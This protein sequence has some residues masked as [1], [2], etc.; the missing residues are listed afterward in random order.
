MSKKTK[1]IRV[2]RQGR[3]LTGL[4]YRVDGDNREQYRGLATDPENRNRKLRGPWTYTYADAKGWRTQILSKKDLVKRGQADKTL[5]TPKAKM[6]TIED[7]GREFLKGIKDGVI[8]SNKD[9]P[10]A[11]STY[12]GYEQAFRDYIFP[13]L[14][15][16]RVNE[17]RRSETQRFIDAIKAIRAPRTTRNI[18][19]ALCALYTYLLPRHDELEHDPTHG[20]K[21]PK[22]GK[23]RQ[24]FAEWD[25]IAH[26]MGCLDDREG[27]PFALAF[28]EGLRNG[29]IR[30]LP[31]DHIDLDEGWIKVAWSL[32]PKE[33][34]KGPKSYSSVRDI[35]IFDQMYPYLERQMERVRA[36]GPIVPSTDDR[37]GTLLLPS[38]RQTR[39][40]ARTYG[41]SFMNNCMESWGWERQ[42][43]GTGPRR[44]IVM[45][46]TAAS[47]E[48]IGLHEG[49]HSFA[50]ALVR[51]EVEPKLVQE[52]VG[53][54][55]MQ[56]T[57][58]VYVKPR[59][60]TQDASKLTGK[61]NAHLLGS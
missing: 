24:R 51:A 52:W 16:K 39:F 15:P 11:A 10:Y 20:L 28:Y 41:N 27:V 25:E 43:I 56:T 34:F 33:G 46:R 1:E 6:P 44:K 32:D 31:C 7:A 30:V 37:P 42:V 12:R 50:T 19:H 36:L 18:A 13:E 38:S 9:E 48:P 8:L 29:E 4:D 17:L 40:G 61:M 35:P 49:R 54:A 55:Q 26:L 60:R 45:H 47:L 23:G 3:E 58:D 2:D 57:Y 5:L 59:G 22:A 14:G 21:L 53:H